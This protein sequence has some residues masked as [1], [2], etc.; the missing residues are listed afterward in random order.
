M[1]ASWRMGRE[2]GLFRPV[3]C[4]GEMTVIPKSDTYCAIHNGVVR[5]RGS[6][7]AMLQFVNDKQRARESG[8][9]LGLGFGPVGTVI[10]SMQSAPIGIDPNAVPF[11]KQS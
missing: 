10:E 8:W 6:K 4:C 1:L 5:A 3:L 7:K 11:V 9:K 2:R